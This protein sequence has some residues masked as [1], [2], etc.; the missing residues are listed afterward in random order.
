MKRFFCLGFAAI[1]IAACGAS[2]DTGSSGGGSTSGGSA[3]GGSTSGSGRVSI[4]LAVS[5]AMN[6]S[7]TQ[8]N[9]YECNGVYL[10]VLFDTF[11]PVI[12]GKEYDLAISVPAKTTPKT[13]D[14]AA[15][16]NHVLLELNDIKTGTG[17]W[18]NNDQSSGTITID[19]GGD[20]GAV[21]A[22]NLTNGLPGTFNTKADLKIK[23][24]CPAKK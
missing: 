23:F 13:I 8:L 5:G 9:K 6:A 12:N 10:G 21:D 1:M 16:D 4:D 17:G 2:T 20:S 3:S 22:H 19:A 18:R 24:V 7:T 14:L 11:S 15:P